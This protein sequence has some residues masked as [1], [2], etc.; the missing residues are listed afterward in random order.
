MGNADS[1]ID[2]QPVS[3]KRALSEDKTD[4]S[5][6]S[7]KIFDNS[8]FDMPKFITQAVEKVMD[9]K[10]M[11]SGEAKPWA[12]FSDDS[13]NPGIYIPSSGDKLDPAVA[14]VGALLGATSHHYQLKK[15][16]VDDS[17]GAAAD[18]N[19]KDYLQGLTY[20]VIANDPVRLSVSE[21]QSQKQIASNCLLFEIVNRG[22]QNR[23]V[24]SVIYDLV[25]ES[26]T[27]S[28]D[29]KKNWVVIKQKIGASL[30][31]GNRAELWNTIQKLLSI[32]VDE[33]SHYAPTMAQNFTIGW[34][35]VEKRALPTESHVVKQGKQKVHAVRTVTLSTPAGSQFL[36]AG[37]RAVVNYEWSKTTLAL[38]TYKRTWAAYDNATR[39]SQFDV[40][41][42]C[43]KTVLNRQYVIQQKTRPVVARRKKKMLESLGVTV[44][45][46]DMKAVGKFYSEKLK[47]FL[48]QT[49]PESRQKA[50]L[51]FAPYELIFRLWSDD[52]INEAF[53]V[54]GVILSLQP[55]IKKALAE[56]Y[57]SYKKLFDI[58]EV[59][60]NKLQTDRNFACANRFA[61]LGDDDGDD[62]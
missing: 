21:K 1:Q 8:K 51:A 53:G 23:K 54:A 12:I 7:R 15:L 36:F 44:S 61:A 60:L 55:N 33:R 50:K 27:G 41:V 29:T 26:F 19:I 48:N 16:E 47:E 28:K 35:S 57:S 38:D 62:V 43:V 11:V 14:L 32:W 30:V 39:W 13:G 22:V 10:K 58:S 9:E 45:K 20:T 52:E 18:A 49:N 37:D 6:K 5:R 40:A 25:P 34:K 2:P 4:V 59:E 46:N 42:G 24:S 17:L 3:N 31:A 56:Q